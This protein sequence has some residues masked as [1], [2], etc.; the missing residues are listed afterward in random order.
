MTIHW[1][2]INKN[3]AI[4]ILHFHKKIKV[5][6]IIAPFSAKAHLFKTLIKPLQK[7]NLK[8]K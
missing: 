2:A 3:L 7:T 5:S 8:E 6:L 1:N 4:T